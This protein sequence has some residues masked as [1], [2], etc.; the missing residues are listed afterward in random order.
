MQK[1]DQMQEPLHP[2][3][4]DTLVIVAHP[5]DAEIS[6]GGTILALK[7]A[8]QKVG[9]IDL[10]NGEPTPFGSPEIRS[11]ETA[12][13][14]KILNLDFRANL[15][16]PN[17][18]IEPTLEARATLAGWIRKL[19]P[20]L[21]ITHHWED[22][23]P[24]HVAASSLVDAARFWGKLSKTSLPGSPHHAKFVLYAPSIHL[25][26]VTKPDIVID[27]SPYL[28]TKMAACRA[29]YSQ[30]VQGRPE[31][32]FG[33]LGDIQAQARFWGWAIQAQ[34]GEPLFSREAL[35]IE[36]PGLLTN[37]SFNPIATTFKV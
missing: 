1:N 3:I 17:R 27:I 32:A 37:P 25:R 21:L 14:T 26:Q 20:K 8:G 35:G 19:K 28:E 33:P 29:Y 4:L 6:V 36:H 30:L 13:A 7:K 31:G 12:E 16:L 22:S 11:L 10:T 24:D 23:H 9:V 34:Y 18:A 2:V 5:D 15:G